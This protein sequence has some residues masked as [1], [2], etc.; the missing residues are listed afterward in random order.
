MPNLC[1]AWTV[2]IGEGSGPRLAWK[3]DLIFGGSPSVSNLNHTYYE[4]SPL[5]QIENRDL[6]SGPRGK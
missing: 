3:I 1:N 4:R 6:G 5:A 2:K